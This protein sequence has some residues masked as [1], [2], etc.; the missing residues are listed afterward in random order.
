M[1]LLP[2]MIEAFTVTD[3]EWKILSHC[4]SENRAIENISNR[5]TGTYKIERSFFVDTKYK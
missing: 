1:Q 5:P 2:H 4:D 3:G